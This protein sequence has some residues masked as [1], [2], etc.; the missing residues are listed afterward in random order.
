MDTAGRSVLVFMSTYNGEKYIE[1]QINTILSQKNVHIRLLIRDDGS[2]DSTWDILK[3]YEGKYSNI[4]VVKGR[5]IGYAASFLTLIYDEQY[6]KADYYAF[7]DQDDIWDEDKMISGIHLMEGY[8]KPIFYY[9]AQRIVNKE[10][11]YIRDEVC[12]QKVQRY[13]KYAASMVRLT[14]GCTQM[15]NN[16]FHEVLFIR[17]PKISEIFE[18]DNWVNLIAFWSADIVYDSIPHIGYRQT[19]DNAIGTYETKKDYLKYALKKSLA[20]M[21]ALNRREKAAKQ[22]E[23]VFHNSKNYYLLT[24]HYR[25]SLWKKMKLLFSK[26]YRE[27]LSLKWKIFNVVLILSNRL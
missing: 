14:R 16:D 2:Q 8:G 23:S 6:E 19:G 24:A 15:W 12:F 18:H 22:F 13:S 1:E 5:N 21:G 11:I 17:R 10:G 20:I 4:R 9:S 3:Y 7:S 26:E 25:E 27:G